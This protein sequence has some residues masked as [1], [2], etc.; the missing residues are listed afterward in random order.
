MMNLLFKSVSNM[1]KVSVAKKS[2][3]SNFKVSVRQN[4]LADTLHFT[5]TFDYWKCQHVTCYN[6]YSYSLTDTFTLIFLIIIIIINVF[7]KR[8]YIYVRPH[9]YHVYIVYSKIFQ[10]RVRRAICN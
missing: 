4:I 1:K 3:S 8:G 7:K 6:S 9:I 10:K 2:D 5:D